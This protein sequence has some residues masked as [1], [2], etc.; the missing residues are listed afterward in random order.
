MST[1]T[2]YPN[3]GHYTE[4]TPRRSLTDFV[5]PTS[6]GSHKLEGTARMRAALSATPLAVEDGIESKKFLWHIQTKHSCAELDDEDIEYIEVQ[7]R[8]F[9]YDIGSGTAIL[10][11]LFEAS[12]TPEAEFDP[13]YQQVIDELRNGNREVLAEEL[14][15]M[16]RNSRENPDEVEIKILSLQAMA[17]F[18]IRQREFDDPVAGPDPS[19]IMQIEWHILGNGLLVMA[20]LE[21]D[22]I[23]CVVQTDATAGREMLNENAQL[24]QREALERFGYL[25]PQR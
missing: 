17:R 3:L 6:V 23:H 20:F 13:E 7:P 12:G 8:F 1:T 4:P 25:V 9:E 22:R 15:E 5:A 19:G 16:L 14:I 10:V 18:L 11:D 21:D 2:R 24:T